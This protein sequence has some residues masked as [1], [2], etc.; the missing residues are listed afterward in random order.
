MLKISRSFRRIAAAV[1][2]V[3]PG[4]TIAGAPAFSQ[5]VQDVTK[6]ISAM[7][8]MKNIAVS[9]VK[10]AGT[11]FTAKVGSKKHA[12]TIFNLGT[13]AKPIWNVALYPASLQM[14]QV[15][16]SG[17]GA[18]LGGISA[19]SL[20]VVVSTGTG[21]GD[22]AK[23][24]AAVQA[25]IKNI[26]GS[27]V[28]KVTFPGGVNFSFLVDPARTKALDPL[29]TLL[30]VTTAKVPMAGQMGA[31]LMGVDGLAGSQ[32]CQALHEVAQFAHVARP[33]VVFKHVERGR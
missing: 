3:F 25:G 11:H 7:P 5:T 4:L 8:E 21:S 23:L 9:D 15:Y 14:S 6:A 2:L 33:S 16:K 32:D 12:A 20:A 18:P 24:P 22:V 10:Q 28:K 1:A 17:G 26:F 27:A 31:D 19:S 29:R 30:G 13:A